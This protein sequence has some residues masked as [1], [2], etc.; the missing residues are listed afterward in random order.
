MNARVD[1][2]AIAIP[3]SDDRD[4][5]LIALCKRAIRAI[6]DEIAAEKTCFDL[7]GMYQRMEPA[8]PT[9]EWTYAGTGVPGFRDTS[10]RLRGVLKSRGRGAAPT[11]RKHMQAQ[12]AA[13]AW[14]E[15]ECRAV[16]KAIG[17]PK[18][19]DRL[20]GAAALA[21]RHIKVVAQL[22]ARTI[23]GSAWKA[24]IISVWLRAGYEIGHDCG[25]QL[26]L[27]I[28][29]DVRL[30]GTG[31]DNDGRIRLAHRRAQ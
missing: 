18:A 4:I 23:L 20:L 17:L 21:K 16:E 2:A 5:A 9:L 14:W 13:L 30:L 26:I 15:R 25:Q 1:P 31:G 7:D 10:F 27:S 28:L 6:E 19:A 3:E 12:I 11:W 29:N 22:P 24:M 8:Y